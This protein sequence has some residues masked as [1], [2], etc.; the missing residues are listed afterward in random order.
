MSEFFGLSYPHDGR[1]IGYSVKPVHHPVHTVVSGDST[2][3]LTVAEVR[4]HLGYG[5]E[6]DAALDAELTAFIK[7]AQRAVEAYLC[8]FKIMSTVIRA[9]VAD[10]EDETVLRMRPYAAF[11]SLEYVNADDG[12]ITTFAATNYHV[13][14]SHQYRARLYLGQGK[15]WPDIADRADAYRLTYSVGWT[16]ETVPADLKAALLMIVA[17][18]NS[19]RGDCEETGA[20]ASVY[21]MQ[22][23]NATAFPPAAVALLAPYKLAEIW[24]I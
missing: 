7:A 6:T 15:T 20:G 17:K 9:D 10:L 14:Q 22:N 8:D 1:G 5:T 11:T 4:A 19:D 23:A 21:A 18:L 3:P 24:S 13:I 2:D 16:A 12:E